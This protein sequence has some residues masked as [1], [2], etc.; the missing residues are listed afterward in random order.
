MGTWGHR[1]FEND[2]A[3]DF[4]DQVEQRG[5]G[6]IEEAIKAVA[7]YPQDDHLKEDVCTAALVAIE[8]IAAAKGNQSEDF[9]ENAEDW[10]QNINP[11]P[12]L[13][14]DGQ[15]LSKV[16]DRVR[17]NSGLRNSWNEKKDP[18]QWLAVLSDL[19]KRVS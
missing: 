6:R 4:V 12:L 5:I 15:L 18:A 19:E 11:E 2:S 13:G 14:T 10:L 8:F 16:I 17:R 1:N 7:N 3:L 9:P